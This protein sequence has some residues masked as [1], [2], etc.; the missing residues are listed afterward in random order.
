MHLDRRIRIQLV[1]YVVIT[2]VAGV[3]MAVGYIRLPA[4]FGVGRYSVTVELPRA[5]G[6]YPG[7]NVTYRGT[8]VGR[9]DQ[10]KLTESG[11][12]AVLSLRSDI[13]IPS[14]LE[15]QV[16]SV[17]SV[18]EQYM[19]LLPGN[20]A[21]ASLKNGDVIPVSRTSV[22][23]DINGVVETLNTGL[24]AIPR[25]NLRTVVDESYT[26][27]GGLGPELARLVQGSTRVVSDARKNIDAITAL[28]DQSAPVLDSQVDTADAI[29]AWS[30]HL[31]TV[32][33]ELRAHDDDMSDV[34]AK[35]GPAIDEARQLFERLQ[36]TVPILMAN[37][38]SLGDVAVAYQPNIEQILVLLPQGTAELQGASLASHDTKQ[39][40][41][42][43]HV[44]F[45]LNINLPPPC[46]TGF[47][48][49]QQRRPAALQDYP[50][51]PAGDVYCRIPQD[52]D[53]VAVRGARNTPC[54]TVP[55]KRAPTV[56]M[57][58]SDEQYVPLNEGTNWKGDPNA[59]LSGQGIPQLPPG[60]PP[61]PAAAMPPPLAVAEY[62]PATGAYVGPDGKVYTQANLA[63]NGQGQTWQSMLIPPN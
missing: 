10:V 22:P 29:S 21:S 55:G 60:P 30:A 57:C 18:G 42:G 26:A 47:L 3:V 8:E 62:D 11:V 7:G 51:P 50:D 40:Y 35:G 23:P 6:L 1:I 9:I 25:E 27:V 58:E 5:A 49:A 13:A 4:M 32:T 19:A 37:L 17:S 39:D 12:A 28:V 48:P 56:K 61:P 59:T 52:S 24:Q 54:A 53:L 46:T 63:Q 20:G 15:A 44:D 36:P 45:N 43:T 38:V 16:H 33:D 34:L 31:A 41:K 14:D 2:L